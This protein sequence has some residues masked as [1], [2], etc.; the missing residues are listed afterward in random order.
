MDPVSQNGHALAPARRGGR[1]QA[2][3]VTIH[4]WL[5][6]SSRSFLA[7]DRVTLDVRSGEFVSLLGPSGCGKT[8]FLNAVDGL[9]PI[10]SGSLSINDKPITGPG[11]DRSVVFQQPSLLPWRTVL[12][13]IT[14]GLEIQRQCSKSEARDR[15]QDLIGMV[16]LDGFQQSY[17]LELSGGMQQRVNLARALAT[18]P[19]V[20]LMD[21]PFGAL[22]AQIREVMQ[23]ELLKIWARTNK[24]VLFVTHDIKEAIYLADRVVVFTARPGRI[25][26]NLEIALPR[27]RDLR[28]KRDAHFLEYEDFIWSTLE[29]EVN[30]A[31]LAEARIRR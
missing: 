9:L 16:G 28:I 27:P 7:V 29:E 23:R 25:K 1:V 31:V 4:Y 10:T 8:T 13:N 3:D 17:P 12:D 11:R 30:A 26:Q 2:R 14:Y 21:E 6:R 15:A 5:T 24:T 19:D 18:D 20:L 22:D